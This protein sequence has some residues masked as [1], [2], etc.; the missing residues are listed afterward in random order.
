MSK[1]Q[2]VDPHLRDL[3]CEVLNPFSR[4]F[5]E[6]SGITR[7]MSVLDVGCGPGAMT[8]WLAEMVGPEG[9]VFAQVSGRIQ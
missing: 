6:R 1:R 3:A 9:H 2:N 7:G 5:L 4:D 8:G